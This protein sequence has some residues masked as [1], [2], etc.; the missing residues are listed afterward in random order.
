MRFLI[1]LI[2]TFLVFSASANQKHEAVQKILQTLKAQDAVELK[3]LEDIDLLMQKYDLRKVKNLDPFEIKGESYY[4]FDKNRLSAVEFNQYENINKS[5]HLF[6]E[7]SIA[8]RIEAIDVE[9]KEAY[10][11]SSKSKLL[12]EFR[13]ISKDCLSLTVTQQVETTITIN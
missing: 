13:L 12:Q 9:I 11:S 4:S 2:S 10:F 1:L 7:A 5:S 8:D 3:D 6:C